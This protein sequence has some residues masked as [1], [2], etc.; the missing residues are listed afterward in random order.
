MPRGQVVAFRLTPAEAE[1]LRDRARAI[2]VSVS[3][4]MHRNVLPGLLM[5]PPARTLGPGPLVF[6]AMTAQF[7]GESASRGAPC[8]VRWTVPPGGVASGNTLTI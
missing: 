8:I 6:D 4:F 2:G 3:E 5:Q 1:H 7:D